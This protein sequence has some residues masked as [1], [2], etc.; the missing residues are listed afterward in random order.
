MKITVFGDG[1]WGTTLAVLLKNKGF[2]VS[3]WGAFK[4]NIEALKKGGENRKFLPGIKIPKGV[5]FTSDAH[6]ACEGADLI[7]LAIPSRFL[8]G[9]L[10][11][12]ID[13]LKASGAGFISVI[14]GLEEKSLERMSEVVLEVLG[15]VDLGVLS[16]PSIASEVSRGVPT[17]VVV[18][19][20]DEPLAHK[21]RDVFRTDTLRVYTNKDII[22]VELGGALKN[23]IAI[24]AGISDGLGFGAN[25]KAAILTRGLFEISRLGAAMG[26]SLET[27]RGLTG[28]GDLVTT[29]VSLESRNRC[30]GEQVAKGKNPESILKE[31][32]MEI[33]G[34]WTSKAALLLGKKYKV[35]L[36]ITEKVYSVLF[37]KKSPLSAVNE[38][39]MREPKAE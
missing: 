18:A 2:D 21:V 31:S 9:V 19:S 7:I 3:L 14:K 29:C 1:S 10:V 16:G 20:I 15:K 5:C 38:L 36:P 32:V 24:A 13:A 39:M 4:D 26:A 11:R 22:G 35:E 28:L 30:F 34:A 37:E 17:A 12:N 27:F 25:T 6:I 33:E 8:R 23:I